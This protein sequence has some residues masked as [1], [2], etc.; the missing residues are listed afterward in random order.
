MVKIYEYRDMKTHDWLFRAAWRHETSCYE[1]W[2]PD[3]SHRDLRD[4]N[5][6]DFRVARGRNRAS[7]GGRG[8]R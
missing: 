6:R 3:E 7:R 4:L 5:Q 2:V 8:D 1:L